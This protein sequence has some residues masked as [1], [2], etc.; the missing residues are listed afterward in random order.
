MDRSPEHLEALANGF[1][2]PN[3]FAFLPHRRVIP[4][5]IAPA[6]NGKTVVVIAGIA[7]WITD[8]LTLCNGY[9]NVF[10]TALGC[11]IP[12]IKA[13]DQ[14]EWLLSNEAK[15]Q[16]WQ[17]CDRATAIARANLGY[18]VAIAAKNPVGNGHIGFGMPEPL[19]NGMRPGKKLYCSAAGATNYA[20]I[21]FEKSFGHLSA[22]AKTF[23]HP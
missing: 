20:K 17:E 3:A 13:N 9:A 1:N 6:P 8:Q 11:P 14:Y 19:V 5:S 12:P 22:S 15:M 21:E 18:P 10:S 4:C 2:V 23:F 7:Y 16:K